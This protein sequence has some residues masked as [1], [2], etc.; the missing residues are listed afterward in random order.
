MSAVDWAGL[1]R[2]GL[3]E[4]RLTPE[5]FW[6][7]TPREL[8]AAAAP[9]R[10]RAPRPMSRDALEALRAR[11]PDAGGDEKQGNER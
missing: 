7:M 11:F 9:W 3:G 10:R 6:S 4:L 8:D 1:M 5:A 2:M